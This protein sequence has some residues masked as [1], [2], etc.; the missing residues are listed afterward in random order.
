MVIIHIRGPDIW[1]YLISPNV[2]PLTLVSTLQGFSSMSP[3]IHFLDFDAISSLYP[4]CKTCTTDP[5]AIVE[6]SPTIEINLFRHKKLGMYWM[7]LE[8]FE[9]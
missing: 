7:S 8:S 6:M 9:V 2:Y 3:L 5:S 4:S 1:L